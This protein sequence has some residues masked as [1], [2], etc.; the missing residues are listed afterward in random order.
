[1]DLQGLRVLLVDDDEAT[2]YWI[3]RLLE[4]LGAT[5]TGA[6][7]ASEAL[8]ALDVAVPDILLCDIAM[9][10]EDGY[11]LIRRVRKRAPEQGGQVPAV[12]LTAYAVIPS[13]V[14]QSLR[15]G[16]QGH[17]TKPMSP[18]ELVTAV[19]GALNGGAPEPP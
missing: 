8:G 11:G 19:R 5:V 13:M 7:S 6:G 1:M 9:P 4:Q 17:L 10:Q 14:Q 15:S 3:T 2:R 16:F 18:E 12:A